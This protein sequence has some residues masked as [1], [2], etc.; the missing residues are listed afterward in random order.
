MRTNNNHWN[1]IQD[2]RQ[3]CMYNVIPEQYFLKWVPQ[4]GTCEKCESVGLLLVWKLRGW[5]TAISESIDD[6]DAVFDSYSNVPL[7]FFKC[8]Y[9]MF[10]YWLSQ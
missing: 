7:I 10:V 8:T 9:L 5:N 3:H 1:K 6:S 4:P 2:L